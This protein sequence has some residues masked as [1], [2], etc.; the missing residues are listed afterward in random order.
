MNTRRIRTS[1]RP[2]CPDCGVTA[3]QSH[4]PD[5]DVERCS[6]CRGQKL[7]CDCADHDPQSS[8]WTGEWPGVVQCRARGWWCVRAKRGWQP[9]PPGTPG[10]IEDLNRL[11]YF[12]QTGED[13][14]YDDSDR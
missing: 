10:A 12:E 8:Y 6:V 7:M 14:L 2:P 3:G 11:A 4:E 9:C 1:Q 13:T 5:C